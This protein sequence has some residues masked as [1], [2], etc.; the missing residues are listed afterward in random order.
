ML[1]AIQKQQ[2]ASHRATRHATRTERTHGCVSHLRA[3][4]PCT[5]ASRP[6]NALLAARKLRPLSLTYSM[7]R[8]PASQPHS[9]IRLC[10]SRHLSS[11][12]LRANPLF[13]TSAEP[14]S[15]SI[16]RIAIREICASRTEDWHDSAHENQSAHSHHFSCCSCDSRR[17]NVVLCNTA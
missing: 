16:R 3:R 13:G 11:C 2:R 5:S 9:H 1:F 17:P 10:V 4:E 14:S 12:R 8:P 6:R 15:L 7:R